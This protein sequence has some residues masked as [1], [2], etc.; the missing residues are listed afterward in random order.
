MV[1]A[2]CW[3]LNPPGSPAALPDNKKEPKSNA[4]V[5]LKRRTGLTAQIG[6]NPLERQLFFVESCYVLQD[7][8][9]ILSLPMRVI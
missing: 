9:T 3:C 4:Q 8:R 1:L 7:Y 2:S 5:A 6:K